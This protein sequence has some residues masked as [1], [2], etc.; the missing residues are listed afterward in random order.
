MAQH[1]TA[2]AA[3]SSQEGKATWHIAHIPNPRPHGHA[4]A[5]AGLSQRLPQSQAMPPAPYSRRSASPRA[6]RTPTRAP[7]SLLPRLLSATRLGDGLP[8]ELS[9]R[10]LALAV[11]PPL[12]LQ[13]LGEELALGALH[14]LEVLSALEMLVLSFSP[15]PVALLL[16]LAQGPHRPCEAP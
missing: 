13:R 16:Y 9:D 14:S 2:A 5:R 3:K 12:L 11:R 1:A 8:P 7:L 10:V 6:D 15:L 4:T